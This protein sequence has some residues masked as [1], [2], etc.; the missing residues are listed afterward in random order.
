MMAAEP[1]RARH[2]ILS[3]GKLSL[4]TLLSRVLG[5]FRDILRAHYFGT[6]IAADAFTVAFRLPNMLRALFAEGALSAAFVPVLSEAIEKG[7]RDEWKRFVL[8]IATLLAL[9]LTL[10]CLIAILLAPYLLPIITPG[11]GRIPGKLELTIQLTQWL[12]PYLLLI[13]MATLAMATLNSLRH[14]TAPAL[15]AAVLNL[16]MIASML[17]VVPRLGQDQSRQVFGLAGGVIVGGILQLAIQLPPLLR[18]RLAIPFQARLR[19]P[20]IRRVG[21]LMFPAVLGMGVAELNAFVDTFL[22]SLLP[23]GSVAALEYGHRVMQLPLGV[24]AVAIGTAVLPTLSRHAARGELESLEETFNQA[25]RLILFILLPMTGLF[26]VLHRPLLALLFEHGAF[27]GGNSLEM[28]SSAFV[29]YT[30]G[31][32][33]YGSVKVIVP[34]FYAR[35]NTRTPVRAA[36][37]AMIANI[38]LNVI[39]MQFLALGGLALATALAS[40]LN[41]LLLMRA[42][43]RQYGIRPR[44]GVLASALRAAAAAALATAAAG[45]GMLLGTRLRLLP[46]V[47]GLGPLAVG[48]AAGA[49]VYLAAAWLLG[50]SE[51]HFLLGFL[52]RRSAKS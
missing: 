29:F 26:L 12:F 28:T 10:V 21:L 39:L 38:V 11:F 18:H 3:A 2:W 35:Q 1:R 7:E 50:S 25:L 40:G 51:M 6:G 41:V 16:A 20:R 34:M 14:F 15:S 24:F 45:G 43:R 46:Q 31:M 52:K 8:S 47:P 17:W 27:A 9:T 49:V 13:G 37:T 30:T 36:I 42:L 23:P 44:R 19:D 5:V 4:G 32:C 22:A 48:I 33:F